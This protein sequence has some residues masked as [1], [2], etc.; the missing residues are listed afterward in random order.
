KDNMPKAL[1]SVDI[2]TIQ[3]WKHHM[4]QWMATYCSGLE[5]KAAQI[6]VKKFSSHHHVPETVACSFD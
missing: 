6:E 2:S 3:K 1:K 4:V 5:A